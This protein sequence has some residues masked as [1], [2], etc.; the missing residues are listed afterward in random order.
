[1]ATPKKPWRPE[2]FKRPPTVKPGM[3]F[4]LL[5]ALSEGP[6]EP[7]IH[8][9]VPG[10]TCYHR[11]W[12]CRCECGVEKVVKQRYLRKKRGE[13]ERRQII[14]NCGHIAVDQKK[15][16]HPLVVKRCVLTSIRGSATA[17]GQAFDLTVDQVWELSQKRCTYCDVPPS[18]KTTLHGQHYNGL[19]RRDNTKGY[20]IDNVT[21][22]CKT[23]NI[24][25]GTMTVREFREWSIRVASQFQTGMA[26]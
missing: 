5:T 12:L 25:K 11:T 21:P 22:C 2:P 4:G 1:M 7:Y 8:P 19:D 23:C 18:N 14:R 16:R 10:C 15:A 26:A 17:R 24:A 13:K 3:V 20:F 6:P 9:N